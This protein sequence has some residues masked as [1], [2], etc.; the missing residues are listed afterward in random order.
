MSKTEASWP[1]TVP[2]KILYAICALASWSVR[3]WP[4]KA[5][6]FFGDILGEFALLFAGY[7]KEVA[8]KNFKIAFPEMTDEECKKMLHK[9]FRHLG[10]LVLEYMISFTIRK[11]D[12]DNWF[13]A[14]D[15][16]PLKEAVAEGKGAIL[17]GTHM[18]PCDVGVVMTQ[19][20]GF[21]LVLV[22]KRTPIH[23]VTRLLFGMREIH[24]VEALPEERV[25][26]DIIRAL[27][28]NKIVV[29]VMDQYLGPPQ[30]VMSKFFGQETGTSQG[31]AVFADRFKVP[32]VPVWSFRREDGRIELVV[33]KRLD[34]T[35]LNQEQI[36]QKCND[37][38]EK[39]VRRVPEQWFWVH[40]RWKPFAGLRTDAYGL[41]INREYHSRQ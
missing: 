3:I 20:A 25:V 33:E 11:S 40:K 12:F 17:L 31:V 8:I 24:G 22:G 23:W 41:E 4:R 36:T 29:M 15:T 26:T 1:A 6:L 30:G 18:G 19:L 37:E 27:K 35:G 28:K 13:V 10:R 9:H 39:M 21:P 14:P 38:I 16:T 2:E 7:R 32:V 34:L 5:Q